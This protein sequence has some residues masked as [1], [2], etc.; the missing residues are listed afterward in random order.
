MANV[1]KRYGT[2]TEL[3][4]ANPVLANGEIAEVVDKGYV[5]VGDGITAFG[6]IGYRGGQT[7]WVSDMGV[8]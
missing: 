6:M 8:P 4:S 5:K 7:Y 2:E 3:T 1:I